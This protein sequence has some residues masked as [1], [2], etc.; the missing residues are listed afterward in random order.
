M[1]CEIAL[2]CCGQ[3][4]EIKSLPEQHYFFLSPWCSLKKKLICELTKHSFLHRWQILSSTSRSRTL[5]ASGS[6]TGQ[7]ASWQSRSSRA[8]RPRTASWTSPSAAW[9]TRTSIGSTLAGSAS[10]ECSAA[11]WMATPRRAPCRSLRRGR[12]TGPQPRARNWVLQTELP[13]ASA[14][15]LAHANEVP[16]EDEKEAD[17]D[18]D[19]DAKSELNSGSSDAEWDSDFELLVD[20]LFMRLRSI[21]K[22][23]VVVNADPT[24]EAAASSASNEDGESAEDSDSAEADEE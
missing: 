24:D 12:G 21:R 7:Q 16:A 23:T 8:S 10:R 15:E 18:N 9:G 2:C 14:V 17:D 13:R 22:R 3:A 4:I 5:Y 19:N 11:C 1:L 6:A 20:K